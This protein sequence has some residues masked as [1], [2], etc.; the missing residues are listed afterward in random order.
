[1]SQ[2]HEEIDYN[3]ELP[4]EG[5]AEAERAEEEID[6]NE[7]ELEC[8]EEADGMNGTMPVKREKDRD[9][10]RDRRPH[11]T[12]GKEDRSRRDRDRISHRRSNIQ[13]STL[14]F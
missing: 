9:R 2:V 12:R 14:A 1:M 6:P 5:V 13:V 10:Q 4:L 3:E 8:I 7:L 11:S